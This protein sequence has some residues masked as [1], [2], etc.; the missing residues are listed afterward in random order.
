MTGDGFA[1]DFTSILNVE[2]ARVVAGS[3]DDPSLDSGNTFVQPVRT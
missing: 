3:A 2:T 1:P